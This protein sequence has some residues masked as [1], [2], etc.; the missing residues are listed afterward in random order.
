MGKQET[1]MEHLV[2]EAGYAQRS[3]AQDLLIETYGKANGK[4]SRCDKLSGVQQDQ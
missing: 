3:L 4:A 2:R 1:V